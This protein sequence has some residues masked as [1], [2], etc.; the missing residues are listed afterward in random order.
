[1]ARY[2]Y[3]G[4]RDTVE[5]TKRIEFSWLRKN[6]YL[7]G[8][9]GGNIKWSINGETTGNINIRVDTYSDLPN[10]KFSYKV[11]R[12]GAEEWKD[13]DF[14]FQIESLPCRFGGKKWFYI[15]GLYINGKYC[16]RRARVLYM[17]GNYFGCRKCANLSYESCNEGKRFR[18]GI[19]KVFSNE[20]KAEEYFQENVKRRFY[21]GKPT[22]KYKRYLR[23]TDNYSEKDL[24]ELEMLLLNNK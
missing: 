5:Q 19:W 2:Y 11:R 21:R 18:H 24:Y 9:K 8:F 16:G 6:D 1:M 3:S 7:C 17:A 10:I 23:L 22:K 4:A 20:I 13:M 15:C 12:Y 14:S